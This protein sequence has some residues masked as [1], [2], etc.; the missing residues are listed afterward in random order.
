VTE[1]TTVRYTPFRY[2]GWRR[3]WRRFTFRSVESPTYECEAILVP[4]KQF[5]GADDDEDVDVMGFSYTLKP[6]GSIRKVKP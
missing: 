5:L 6:V 1:T 2:T 3:W 4:S